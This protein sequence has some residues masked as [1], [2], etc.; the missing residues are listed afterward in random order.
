M[1]LL[2]KGGFLLNNFEV[3]DDTESASNCRSGTTTNK[4]PIKSANHEKITK[5][6][7]STK[8]VNIGYEAIG[9]TFMESE[10]LLNLFII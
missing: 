1:L 2:E 3:L 5:Q 8:I 7:E 6:E 9:L 10:L 4:T